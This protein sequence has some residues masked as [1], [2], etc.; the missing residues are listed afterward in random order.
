M[1]II[2]NLKPCVACIQIQRQILINPFFVALSVALSGSIR[3]VPVYTS[4]KTASI[5][6]YEEHSYIKINEVQVI[7]IT[8]VSHRSNQKVPL[9]NAVI[10]LNFQF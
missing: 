9:I 2:L 5:D 6:W 8:Y 3:D 7:T 1:N 4:N 10:V